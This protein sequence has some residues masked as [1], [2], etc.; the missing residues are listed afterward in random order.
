MYV[1]LSPE[2]QCISVSLLWLQ[3]DHIFPHFSRWPAALRPACTRAVGPERGARAG[4]VPTELRGSRTSHGCPQDGYDERQL[5]A[6]D[7]S[8]EFFVCYLF[9]SFLE[10]VFRQ[11][12]VRQLCDVVWYVVGHAERLRRS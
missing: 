6:A 10:V 4:A 9:W 3:V 1:C 8:C 12:S 5:P 7:G 11:L 2:N